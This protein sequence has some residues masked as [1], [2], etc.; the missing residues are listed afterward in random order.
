MMLEAY[1]WLFAGHLTDMCVLPPPSGPV[2]PQ[3]REKSPQGILRP[4]PYTNAAFEGGEGEGGANLLS[5]KTG[6]SSGDERIQM[7]DLTPSQGHRVVVP[8]IS[9]V[10]ENTNRN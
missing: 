9:V 2:C 10:C 6:H 8:S 3:G 5:G 1:T 4:I 7:D